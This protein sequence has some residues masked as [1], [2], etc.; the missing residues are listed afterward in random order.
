MPRAKKIVQID[1]DEWVT[2]GWAKQLEECCD[3]GLRHSVDYR[4]ADGGK[5][6]MRAR[7]VR[8]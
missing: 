4:V 2:I 6:Q 7:R 8:K 5:L 3:C 1:D